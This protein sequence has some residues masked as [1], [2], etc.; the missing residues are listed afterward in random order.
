MIRKSALYPGPL[1]TAAVVATCIAGALGSLTADGLR[2]QESGSVF[3]ERI[4][5]YVELNRRCAQQLVLQGIDPTTAAGAAYR[6]KLADAVRRARRHAQPGDVFPSAIAARVQ[7]LVRDDLAA[8]PRVDR[9][10]IL[11]GVPRQLVVRV[12][13]LYPPAEP[14]ATVPPAL[15]LRLPPLPPELQ[16]RF[17]DSSL[18]LLD[19]EA[20]LIVDVV[21]TALPRRP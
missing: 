9:A 14:L 12:N 10:A 20:G 8:R 13:D 1:A 11:E 2:A 18:V 17:L 7:Q 15:L 19:V 21:P 4:L 6:Q 16:Y 3:R 5:I